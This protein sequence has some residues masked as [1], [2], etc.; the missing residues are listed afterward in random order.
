MAYRGFTRTSRF[1]ILSALLFAVLHHVAALELGQSCVNPSGESGSC[2]LF[3]ECQPLVDIFKKPFNTPDDTEFLQASRCGASNGKPLVCCAG[4]VVEER[5]TLPE[6]PNCGTQLSDRIFGGQPTKID[7]FPWTALIEYE[8][9]NGRFGFHCG[10]SLINQRYIVTAAHCINAI[11]R[12]W[13]VH[14][15]RLG[16]WDLSTSSD[17][18]DD[19][20][21]TSPIDLDIEQ[22]IVHSGIMATKSKVFLLMCLVAIGGQSVLCLDLG[23]S[24]VNPRG[25]QGSCIQFQECQPLVSIYNKP[26]RTDDDK[27]FLLASRCGTFNT[28]TL[29]CCVG[30][31]SSGGKTTLPQPPHCGIQLTDR[32][33]GGQP[34]KIDEF[35]WTALIEFQKADG[36]FGFHC[37][38]S[39]INQRY[40]VTAAHCINAIPRSW[41]PNRIR[42]GEW[43]LG[44]NSDCLDDFCAP[45]PVDLEIEK[46][47]VHPGYDSRDKANL[48]DIAL[49]RFKRDVQ[50]SDVIRPICLPL[51]TSVRN[52]NYVGASSYAAGWGK[53]ETASASDKKLKVELNIKSQEDCAPIF[54]RGGILL[55]PSQICAGG[56]R[57]KDT[58]SGDSGGPLMRQVSGTWYLLGVVAGAGAKNIPQ[59][60]ATPPAC[61][62]SQSA[63]ITVGSGIQMKEFP[64]T[65]LI[66]Y[67]KPSGE[68]EFLCGGA[69]IH[70]RY[71]VTAAHCTASIPSGWK[72][73]GLK[74]CSTNKVPDVYTK[75]PDYT[76]WIQDNMN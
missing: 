58:C 33:V 69:L 65:V 62:Q 25:Q 59:A 74:T 30:S 8:K 5:T 28:K 52:R 76:T 22:I 31:A 47:I 20:C 24:C 15:V 21:S 73:F 66:E 29:V 40:I 60:L 9:P 27:Q 11:P 72:F 16:E 3:R 61:G 57:G 68:I 2:I 23:Q 32:V 35:P 64:W 53:T 39:L 44:S 51:S 48:N 75:V 18:E 67:E 12:G 17:C 37:G 1:H 70:Q 55:K 63:R 7:E 36:R 71:V 6:P 43:D 4:V 41:K 34:T 49:I 42:L 56:V 10:G 26:I 19:F 14:R 50:Y 13:K 54:A 45:A 38:G 46:I